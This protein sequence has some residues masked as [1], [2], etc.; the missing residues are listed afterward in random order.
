MQGYFKAV[1]ITLKISKAQ[2]ALPRQHANRF[3]M[4]L[5]LEQLKDEH[6]CTAWWTGKWDRQRKTQPAR[7]SG[8][9]MSISYAE[10]LYRFY[11]CLLTA[12]TSFISSVAL[13]SSIFSASFFFGG[14]VISYHP[15]EVQATDSPFVPRVVKF[16][17]RGPLMWFLSKYVCSSF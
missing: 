11:M 12:W 6:S 3:S 4:W 5:S 9:T 14:G 13:S 17:R 16:K 2:T 8:L 10:L 15:G 7:A 1:K